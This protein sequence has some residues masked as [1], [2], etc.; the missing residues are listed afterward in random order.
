MPW[1]HA[2]G[3]PAVHALRQLRAARKATL[4]PGSMLDTGHLYP[5]LPGRGSS[6]PSS[7]Q[8]SSCGALGTQSS[9]WVPLPSTL[10]HRRPSSERCCSQDPSLAGSQAVTPLPGLA[11]RPRS[12][13]Q[14]R[15]A[16]CSSL[17]SSHSSSPHSVLLVLRR[18]S[19]VCS[20]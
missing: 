12:R 10:F 20:I 7:H 13:V 11:S 18:M 3:T 2:S 6:V 9:P 16:G 14:P 15:A 17:A 8:A 4:L 19:Q 1:P 5:R